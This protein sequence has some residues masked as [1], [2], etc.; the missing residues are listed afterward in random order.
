M[1]GRAKSAAPVEAATLTAS[2]GW[3]ASI[4]RLNGAVVVAAEVMQVDGD[5]CAVLVLKL[6]LKGGPLVQVQAMR[7]PEGNGFGTLHAVDHATGEPFAM[8]GGR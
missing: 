1:S 6:K 2:P 5:A 8:W 4:E 3:N 7:D